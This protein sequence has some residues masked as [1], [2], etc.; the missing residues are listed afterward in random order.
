M[1]IR[2][3]DL[4]STIMKKCYCARNSCSNCSVLK[5]AAIS[6][7]SNDLLTHGTHL[8]GQIILSASVCPGNYNH[9]NPQTLKSPALGVGQHHISVLTSIKVD[10][11]S[12]VLSLVAQR[13]AGFRRLL[14][15]HL[16]FARL[17]IEAVL[18]RVC[19]GFYFLKCKKIIDFIE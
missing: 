19:G 10:T 6:P 7:P 5:R 3:T 12:P 1:R 16:V 14:Y 17:R 13:Y 18:C 8:D 15:Q 4:P 9:F 2:D 11:P